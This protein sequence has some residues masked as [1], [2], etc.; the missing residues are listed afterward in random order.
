M[1]FWDNEPF[2]R[3]NELVDKNV[4]NGPNRRFVGKSGLILYFE[5]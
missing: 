3:D 1:V 2:S 5:I 4:G